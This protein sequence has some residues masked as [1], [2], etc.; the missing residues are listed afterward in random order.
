MTGMQPYLAVRAGAGMERIQLGEPRAH[1]HAES[2]GGGIRKARCKGVQG[3]SE[4]VAA[5]RRLP[6]RSCSP[7]PSLGPALFFPLHCRND[8]ALA[9]PAAGCG[10][11]ELAGRIVC[12]IVQGLGHDLPARTTVEV[13][14]HLT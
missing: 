14:I 12:R 8:A 4:F 3:P 10:Q 6:R 7:S 11:A 2:G 5:G 13:L 9:P 1:A